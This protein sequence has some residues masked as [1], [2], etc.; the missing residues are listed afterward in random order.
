[1]HASAPGAQQSESFY[2]GRIEI[3]GMT[4]VAVISQAYRTNSAMVLGGPSW[5]NT[6]RYDIIAKA[7]PADSSGERLDVMLQNLLSERFQLVVR[8]ENREMPVYL[9]TVAKKGAKL[10]PAAKEGPPSA[11]PGTGDAALNNRWGFQSYKMSDLA[12]VLPQFSRDFV[13]LPAVDETGLTG[14][15]DFQLDWM[16]RTL[17]NRA[18]AN[19]DGPPAVGLHEALDKIGLKLDEG[20]R[21]WPVL[22]VDSVKETATPNAPGVTIPKPT[23]PT[24]FDIAEVRPAKSAPPVNSGSSGMTNI[25]LGQVEMMGATLK[26]IIAFAFDQSMDRIAGPK[27]ID[28]ERFDIIAKAPGN[29]REIPFEALQVM[30]KNLV[31]ARFHLETHHE[32]Q[33]MDVFVLLAG[34]KPKLTP[35]DGTA[36]SECNRVFRGDKQ[37][38]ATLACQN[39]SMAQFVERLPNFAGMYIHPPMLD[40]TGIQGAYDFEL[41]WTGKRFLAGANQGA[42]AGTTDAGGA[43]ALPGSLTVFEALDQQ[44]G[45]KA[46]EQKHPVPKLVVDK[47]SQPTEN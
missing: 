16:D 17:Y 2:G 13:N 15:Y 1:M 40:L 34:K 39:T 21:P 28:E 38:N 3:H 31:V 43:A 35:S 22:I 29:A 20:K 32:D 24:E 26:A 14:T 10:A 46:T 12:L 4:L 47:A 18:K 6:N 27:W 33:P 25:R 37:V 11:H 23:Y 30:L 19:P 7:P 45:L 41:T 36:R 5:L 44:L 42:G 8:K 9:L